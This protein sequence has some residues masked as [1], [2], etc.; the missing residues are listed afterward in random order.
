M[1]SKTKSL[2]IFFLISI[3]TIVLSITTTI[4]VMN[5]FDRG[6]E[7]Q[8]YEST[9]PVGN[10]AINF[11]IIPTNESDTLNFTNKTNEND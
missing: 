2:L 1:D 3:T 9:T 7:L 8:I 11:G 4:F 5:S 6:V 10:G